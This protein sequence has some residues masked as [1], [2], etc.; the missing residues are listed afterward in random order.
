MQS[1][2]VEVLIDDAQLTPNVCG[3]LE[4]VGAEVHVRNLSRDPPLESSRQHHARLVLTSN[5]DAVVEGKLPTLIKYCEA[6]PCAT[7]V[8]GPGPVTGDRRHSLAGRHAIDFAGELTL[9]DLAGRL[10]TMCSLQNSLAT[11]RDEVNTLKRKG[12]DSS[13]Q[14]KELEEQVRLARQVQQDLL[15]KTPPSI[16]GLKLHTWFAPAGEISGD[17]Y[18]VYRLDE[19]HVAITLADATGH[20]IPAALLSVF[21]KRSMYGKELIQDSYRLLQ[22]TEVL[23]RLNREMV[24][25]ELSQCQ[26]LAALY[27]VYDEGTGILRWA[28]GG[29]PFP[30]LIRPGQPP[31]QIKSEGPLVGVMTDARFETAEIQLKPQDAVLFHTDGVDDLLA[32]GNANRSRGELH[33]T[34]WFDKLGRVGPW[35]QISALKLLRDAVPDE[36]I[37]LDDITV[38]AL[39]AT[40]T[41]VPMPPHEAASLQPSLLR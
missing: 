11:L 27:A 29:S 13:I 16:T 32:A 14:L 20:G 21:I 25:L 19:S 39:Q 34:D 12:T 36:G 5:R 37:D 35:Q 31:H 26:F 2:V 3:A 10:A 7:L 33:K 15:P 22:P 41:S 6:D 24:R 18:D 4:R 9:S 8:L 30:I 38:I 23:E 28:R 17:M 1:P 40:A